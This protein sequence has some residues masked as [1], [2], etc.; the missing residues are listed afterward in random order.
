MKTNGSRTSMSRLLP[1][2]SYRTVGHARLHHLANKKIVLVTSFPL[3]DI[4]DRPETLLFDW[5][6]FEVAGDL[7]KLP[8]AIAT[9]QRYEVERDKLTADSSR[10]EVERVLGMLIEASKPYTSKV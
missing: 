2:S 3:P 8:D 4:T 6:D 10:D 5:E 1:A 7:D 9:R